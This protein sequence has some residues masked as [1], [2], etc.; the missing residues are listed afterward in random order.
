MAKEKADLILQIR[1][2][3]KDVFYFQLGKSQ[4]ELRKV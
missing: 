2:M 4:Q 1:H 3:K